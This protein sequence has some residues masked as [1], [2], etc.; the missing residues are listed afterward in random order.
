M[1]NVPSDNDL[2]NLGETQ[3]YTYTAL[4]YQVLMVLVVRVGHEFCGYIVPVPG[5]SHDN[6]VGLWATDGVK[7][8]EAITK[9]A[10]GGACEHL[11]SLGYRWRQ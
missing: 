3:P 6:E 9:A 10:L 7:T 2:R 8:T 4:H 5:K 11:E 1:F